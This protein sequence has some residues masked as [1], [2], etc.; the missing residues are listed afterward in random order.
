MKNLSSFVVL[1]ES[2][3]LNQKIRETIPR[4]IVVVR[5]NATLYFGLI[6]GKDEISPA[7]FAL[8]DSRHS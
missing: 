2:A 5:F 6:K 8:R 1:K 4:T 7:F 3:S